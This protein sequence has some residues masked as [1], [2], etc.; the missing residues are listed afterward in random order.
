MLSSS[1]ESQ[2]LQAKKLVKE[3]EDDDEARTEAVEKV[4]SLK[5]TLKH[6]KDQV[7][8]EAEEEV[9]ETKHKKKQTETSNH[10]T[11]WVK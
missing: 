3:A 5:E 2:T 6:L 7:M 4:N 8:D 9:V 1:L 10:I 11:Q